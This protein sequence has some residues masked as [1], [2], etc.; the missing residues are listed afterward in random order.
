MQKFGIYLKKY[1]DKT[2]DDLYFGE[3][4]FEQAEIK[5]I[6]DALVLIMKKTGLKKEDIEV[7]I[8][9]DLLNQIAAS[10]YG[11]YGIGKSIFNISPILSKFSIL[12]SSFI[13]VL[14]VFTP[15]KDL[16]IRFSS[17]F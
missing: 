2:Y 16:I 4:T 14:L 1:F 8:G 15:T 10:T 5:S 6:K 3:K 17:S 7:M 13:V 9:G 11:T 12:I